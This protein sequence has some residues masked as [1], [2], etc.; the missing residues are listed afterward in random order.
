MRGIAVENATHHD[1]GA[2]RLDFFAKNLG[3]IRRGENRLGGVQAHFAAVDIECGHDFDVPRLI[4][5]DLPVHQPD[6]G[7]VAGRIPIEVDALEERTGAVPHA[8][9]GNSDFVH[10]TKS[11]N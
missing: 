3:A 2:G 11:P 4:G 9:N 1:D 6:I 10:R 8:D 5:T 7:A